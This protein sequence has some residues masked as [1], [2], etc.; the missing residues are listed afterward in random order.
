MFAVLVFVLLVAL[1][2]PI[3]FVREPGLKVVATAMAVAVI[4][5]PHANAATPAVTAANAG[6]APAATSAV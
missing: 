3:I 6:T 5:V 1:A 2:I 4:L